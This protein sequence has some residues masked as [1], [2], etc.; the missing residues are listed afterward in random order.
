MSSILSY[1]Q[2]SNR[3][4]RHFQR[5]NL[6]VSGEFVWM[7]KPRFGR[8]ATNRELVTTQNLSVLGTK[9][10]LPGDWDLAEGAR[11]RFKLGSEFCDAEVM[12]AESNGVANTVRLRFLAPGPTFIDAV[13]ATV[14]REGS[15][16][17]SLHKL[18]V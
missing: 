15:E 11:G 1:Q 5:V 14:E 7:S 3:E 12:G 18:W 10:I 2:L 4:R 8:T 9:V 16:R 17:F 13:K 6:H